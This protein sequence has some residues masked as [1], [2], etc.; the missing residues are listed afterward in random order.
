MQAQCRAQHTIDCLVATGKEGG[1][2]RGSARRSSLKGREIA[3]VNQANI[4]TVSRATFGD[5]SDR[6]RGALVGF[7]E[8]INI[9]LS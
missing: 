1:V 3:I 2:D 4:G 9:I 5:T 7:S 8:R 6:R